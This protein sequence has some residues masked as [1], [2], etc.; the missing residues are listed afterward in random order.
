MTDPVD[1][2]PFPNARIT[3]HRK[4]L[5]LNRENGACR[6]LSSHL[7]HPAAC[8]IVHVAYLNPPRPIVFDGLFP[9][10]SP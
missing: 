8:P 4:A 10:Q 5:P 3:L 7:A 1:P 6:R 9:I 2:I